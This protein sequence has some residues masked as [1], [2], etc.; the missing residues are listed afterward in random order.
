MNVLIDTNLLIYLVEGSTHQL[1][2]KSKAA[3]SSLRRLHCYPTLVPQNIYEFW[4]VATRPIANN[5]LGMTPD[6]TSE[7]LSKLAPLFTLLLDERGIYPRWRSLVV[8][9]AVKGKQAHDARLVAAMLRHGI[10]RILTF[11][12]A[13]FQRFEEIEALTPA[14][15]LAAE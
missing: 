15:V 6:E 13:D 11:N 12:D 3:I 5:G 1:Y 2:A 14:S 9:H 10:K 8:T 4:V 7:E